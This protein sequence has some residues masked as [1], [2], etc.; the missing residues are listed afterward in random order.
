M[1][2]CECIGVNAALGLRPSTG[3]CELASVCGCE[4]DSVATVAGAPSPFILPNFLAIALCRLKPARARA[5][6]RRDESGGGRGLWRQAESV[7]LTPSGLEDAPLPPAINSGFPSSASLALSPHI[8]IST[9]APILQVLSQSPLQPQLA[10]SHFHKCL[11]SRCT[12]H[13]H[14]TNPSSSPPVCKA[15]RRVCL[16][17]TNFSTFYLPGNLY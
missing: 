8:P 9:P 5:D 16:W 3:M 2:D 1:C 11:I 15:K 12:P 17:L 4:C 7:L 13:S 6:H 10:S 14:S